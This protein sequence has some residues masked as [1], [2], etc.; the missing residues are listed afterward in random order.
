MARDRLPAGEIVDEIIAQAVAPTLEAEG[1][2]RTGR[3]FHRRH[4]E[5][6]QVVNV[7]ESA[8]GVRYRE[9]LVYVGIAFDAICRLAGLPVLEQPVMFRPGAG[10]FGSRGIVDRLESRLI[11]GARAGWSVRIRQGLGSIG[12][13][14]EE[15]RAAMERLAAELDRIDGIAAYRAHPWFDRHHPLP[16]SIQILYLLGDLDGAWREIEG[17]IASFLPEWEGIAMPGPDWYVDRLNL[18]DLRS[19]LARSD[20]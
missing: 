11:P 13:A 15:A 14:V 10:D 2:R 4:G 18:D 9:C 5:A 3:D 7:V 17:F 12:P 19:R 20:G 1:F 6:V 8:G 16:V